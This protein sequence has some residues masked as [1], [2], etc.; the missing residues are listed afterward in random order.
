MFYT[1][2]S[3]INIGCI[4]GSRTRTVIKL[5]NK[6]F[7]WQRSLFHR[8]VRASFPAYGSPDTST[9][10]QTFL[11]LSQAKTIIFTCVNFIV[12]RYA[13]GDCLPPYSTHYSNKC[14]LVLGIFQMSQ[15]VHFNIFR[16]PTDQAGNVQDI[17]FFSAVQNSG[18]RIKRNGGCVVRSIP[19]TNFHVFIVKISRFK[20]GW[21]IEFD[22]FLL[23]F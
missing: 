16:G 9:N 14:R 4:V 18:Q 5:F 13:Q 15:M 20:R 8:T 6:G 7:N 12:T 11:H 17:R 23:L 21:A 3:K 1:I 10:L 2:K 22:Y 19:S